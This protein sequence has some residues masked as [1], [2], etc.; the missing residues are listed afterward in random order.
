MKEK[1]KYKSKL[2]TLY[3]TEQYP[4]FLKELGQFISYLITRYVE[5]A[6]GSLEESSRDELKDTLVFRVIST[7]KERPYEQHRADFRTYIYSI[8]RNGI[9]KYLNKAKRSI[10]L[11]DEM[12]ALFEAKGYMDQHLVFTVKFSQAFVSIFGHMEG[13][14]VEK[15]IDLSSSSRWDTRGW[16]HLSDEDK[17]Y[18]RVF[19][20]RWSVGLD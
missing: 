16:K 19:L 9:T 3:F 15:V 4:S 7:L 5:V 11:T 20:W 2:E 18:L 17:N 13:W 6:V 14:I 12:M 1:S 8:A 10:R